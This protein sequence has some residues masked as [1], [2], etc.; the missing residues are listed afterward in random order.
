MRVCE[1]E[2][3]PEQQ[4]YILQKAILTLLLLLLQKKDAREV[5]VGEEKRS[6]RC[7]WEGKNTIREGDAQARVGKKDAR[8]VCGW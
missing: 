6:A 5:C 8:E 1:E 7:V 2:K 3:K 4:N